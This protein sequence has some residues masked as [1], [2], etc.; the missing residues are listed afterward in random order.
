MVLQGDCTNGSHF[1]DL[2]AFLFGPASDVQRILPGRSLGFD[3]EP[4]VRVRFGPVDVYFLAAREECFSMREL[5]LISDTCELR[6]V[7]GAKASRSGVPVRIRW[8]RG[9]RCSPSYARR[10]RLTSSGTSYMSS[11]PCTERSPPARRSPAVAQML[12]TR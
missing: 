7:L 9:I 5:Q 3:V 2:L 8:S 12:S 1:V 10:L 6:Y 11:R 4:D